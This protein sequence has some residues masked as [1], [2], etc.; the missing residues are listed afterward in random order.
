MIDDTRTIRI[1]LSGNVD[2]RLCRPL[3][4]SRVNNHLEKKAAQLQLDNIN[5]NHGIQR[6]EKEGEAEG[7]PGKDN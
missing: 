7:L 5:R 4:A 1:S 6:Q 3:S 2:T